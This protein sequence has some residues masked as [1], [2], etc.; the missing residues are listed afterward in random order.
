[1]ISQTLIYIYD[2]TVVYV[3]NLLL[4]RVVAFQL[5]G[6]KAMVRLAGSQGYVPG[7]D[8]FYNTREVVKQI[9]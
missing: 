3:V 4:S 8:W 1:M 2:I 5:A 6:H 9:G 7:V